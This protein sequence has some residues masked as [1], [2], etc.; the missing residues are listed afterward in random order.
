MPTVKSI[1][2]LAQTK[3]VR[4]VI[5]SASEDLKCVNLFCE[6]VGGPCICRIERVLA[7]DDLK[8]SVEILDLSV[9]K[10]TQL[11]PSLYKLNAMKT[12]TLR[13]N[14]LENLDFNDFSSLTNLES[15]DLTNNPL[16]DKS[17]I[18]DEFKR[19][20]PNTKIIFDTTS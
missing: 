12:L 17:N 5:L 3:I 11:P 2:Q 6:K 14:D 20:L 15:I 18:I 7:R 16:K 10:L 8:S 19:I 4:N 1:L 9:N 13:D